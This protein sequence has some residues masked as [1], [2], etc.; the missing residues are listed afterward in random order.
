MSRVARLR[1]HRRTGE[2]PPHLLLVVENV[3][4]G[5][6]IRARKQVADLAR[7]GYRVSVV[8][9][10]DADNAP[11][12]AMPGV[13]LYQYPAPEE[14]S[15]LAGYVREY[16]V[17]FGWA[18]WLCTL[19]RLRGPVDVVQFCQ[20]P[21]IYFP[22]AWVLRMT[23]SRVLVDQRDLMP[24]LL[25]SRMARRR[26]ILLAGLAWL[27]RRTQRVAQQTVCVND[28]LRDRAVARGADAGQVTIVRNGPVMERVAEAKPDPRLRSGMPYLCC[29]VG[30]MGRQDRL[31][32]LLEAVAVIVHDLRRTDCRF[33]LLGDGEC[34]DEM[35]AACQRLGLQEHVSFTGWLPE[36]EVFAYLATAD[37]GVDTSLQAEVS[38]VKVMEY[39]AFGLP[40]VAFD[41]QET[42]A[43]AA[44]AG[45]LVRPGDARTLAAEI[46]G[47]L[48]SEPDRRVLGAVGR[49]RV[50][51]ELSWERQR[52]QYLDAV[53]RLVRP[54]AGRPWLASTAGSPPVVP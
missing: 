8:T 54:D 11:F 1:G 32:L 24:E 25:I 39:M 48:A 30:K 21:D 50:A 53:G 47:L 33:A 16:L 35:R 26:P 20:P 49:A 38:P 17:S 3:P 36:R 19:A 29:W 10:R 2:R 7:A 28:Y 23:G 12:A 43:I 18:A 27:E 5:V 52:V 14:P 42:R 4:V 51:D 6:D 9:R 22:L 34:L 45:H 44:G 13:R 41:L 40:V 46:T 31:D 37:L 15:E